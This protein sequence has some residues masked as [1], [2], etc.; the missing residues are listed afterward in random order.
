MQETGNNLSYTYNISIRVHA[1]GFS[2][3]CYNPHN[4]PAIKKESYIFSSEKTPTE[5]L[6][7]A[8][9]QSS[10]LKQED[11]VVYG[12]I[13]GPSIQVPLEHF[14]KEEASSLLQL[15]Y[16]QQKENK[17]YYNILPHLEVVKIFSI[18][19]DLEEVLCRHFPSIRFY[20][21]HTM[22]MEKMAVHK[23]AGKQQLFVYLY[24][25]D[26][27]LLKY[28]SQALHYANTFPA[29]TTDN[30]IFYILS[31]WKL[32]GMNAETDECIFLGDHQLQ[33]GII[34]ILN[35]YLRN[36]RTLMNSEL[37]KRSAAGN[38]PDI[39]LDVLSLLLNT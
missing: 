23:T 20:H 33:N 18:S 14:K 25:K 38:L 37:Y 21:V 15:T 30:I 31:V 3:Y 22:I 36:I 1:D 13:N 8:L 11:K 39:P 17:I 27:F 6:E 7:E 19:K 24:D 34:S 10:L 35:Q 4:V 32:L 9:S 16:S 2:F 29:D 12:L 26:I 5:C 28:Q